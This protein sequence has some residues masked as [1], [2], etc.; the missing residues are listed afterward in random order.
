MKHWNIAQSKGVLELKR[1]RRETRKIPKSRSR[2]D[3]KRFD[4]G[5]NC[6]GCASRYTLAISLE[7]WQKSFGCGGGRGEGG[8][9]AFPTWA[10]EK[11]PRVTIWKRQRDKYV[12][13]DNAVAWHRLA[14][15]SLSLSLFLS[16]SSGD[17]FFIPVFFPRSRAAQSISVENSRFI[18][19]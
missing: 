9:A 14:N 3:N 10:H 16:G 1:E 7:I 17:V 13:R 5:D 19:S 6:L 18:L 15:L 2:N 4:G 8:G 12:R 11:F